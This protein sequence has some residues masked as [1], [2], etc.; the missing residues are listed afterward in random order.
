MK[1]YMGLRG[2]LYSAIALFCLSGCSKAPSTSE[3]AAAPAVKSA[4]EFIASV[5][6]T[7]LD[8]YYEYNAAQ[9]VYVTYLNDDS[10]LLATKSNEK[11]M[12]MEKE[13]L[14]EARHYKDAPMS[15]ATKKAYIN[16]TQGKTLLPPDTPEARAELARIGTHMEGV[17]GAGKYCK[18][19]GANTSDEKNC[20]DLNQL[21]DVL[22]K[23]RDYNELVDAWTGWHS[24]A[25]AYR[26][27]YQRYVE[28][29]NS[30]AR[31]YG[32]GDLGASWKSG[33]DMPTN[34]FENEVERLWQQV[35]PLYKALHCKVRADLAKQYGEDK[36]PLNKPIP[37]H[38]LGNMWSQQWDGIYDLVEPYPGVGDLDITAALVKQNKDAIAITKIAENFFT[39]LGLRA[40]PDSFWKKSMLTKPRDREVVC[41]A[42]AWTMDAKEDVRIKQ[43]VEPTET[44]F[45]TIHHE[46]GHIYYDL[47]YNDKPM[48]FQNGANDGF[49]EAIGDTIVLSI[50]PGYLNAIGL[51]ENVEANEQSVIN[52]QMK[53]ALGKIAFL[54]F[55]KLMDQWR[56]KVF[57]G[58]I[59][60]E[61]Y[62]KAWWELRTQYQGITPP[63]ERTEQDFD[64]GA[65]YHI[66]ANVPYTRYFIAHILQ[67]Q[68]HK[69]LCDAAGFKGPLHECSIYNSK[70]AGK[71]LQTM[72]A[73]GASK[74]WQDVLEEAIGTR[75]MDG[76]AIIDYF[77]PLMQWLEKENQGQACGW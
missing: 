67:F 35:E 4:D 26:N 44:E 57:S 49:H 10:A 47:A 40:L 50:T 27:D 1:N 69:A 17:Y 2:F 30:G 60:P 36:V 34:E 75:Q 56:W 65:K 39:S 12:A 62:N 15:A 64:A 54:P 31:A 43:C 22:A 68:F 76:S 14:A 21:S 42:S 70:E 61:D 6:K 19:E 9:W 37:A 77:A 28:I 33:Y 46:L 7:Y 11:W 58:E 16:M 53:L 41:H 13:L 51:I 18:P 74:P 38:L 73:A 5:N 3:V 45:E 24:I 25:R 23:S 71:K 8:N 32:F 52:Q 20:R 55:G 72:L 66:A 48:L 29:A 59:K 63:V